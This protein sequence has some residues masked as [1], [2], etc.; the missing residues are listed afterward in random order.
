MCRG[1]EDSALERH[2]SE[3]HE[4]KEEEK[5]KQHSFGLG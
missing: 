1:E 4:G 2:L 5:A 3:V